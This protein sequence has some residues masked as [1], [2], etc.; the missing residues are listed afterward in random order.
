MDAIQIRTLPQP[1]RLAHTVLPQ[2]DCSV[3][4]TGRV[5]LAV[6][7]VPDTVYRTKMFLVRLE[8]ATCLRAHFVDVHVLSSTHEVSLKLDRHVTLDVMGIL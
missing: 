2:P 8:N 1:V 3:L 6:R 7:R 4:A 5:Q